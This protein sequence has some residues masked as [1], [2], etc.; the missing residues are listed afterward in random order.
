MNNFERY[1]KREWQKKEIKTYSFC[2]DTAK[3]NWSNKE[4]SQQEKESVLNSG[5]GFAFGCYQKI[6]H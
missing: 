6:T 2:Q 1:E 3:S 4:L 5:F